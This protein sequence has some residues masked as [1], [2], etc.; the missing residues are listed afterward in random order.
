MT[1]IIKVMP[2]SKLKRGFTLIELLI[3]ITILGILASLTLA[4]Y[5]SAQAK[6]RDGVRKS[7]LAQVKRALELAKADCSGNAWYPFV[8]NYA[9]LRTY[10]GSPNNYMTPVPLDPTNAS[11]QVYAFTPGTSN[12]DTTTCP[13]TTAGTANYTLSVRLERTT[14][15][16]GNKSWT[17]CTGKPG[18][19]ATYTAGDYYVCNL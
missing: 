19:P 7:D 11:P 6:G 9:A 1:L 4:S 14:D 5:S 12:A 17:D 10:L 15:Q 13:G 16:A 3:V 8:A 18:V 2:T